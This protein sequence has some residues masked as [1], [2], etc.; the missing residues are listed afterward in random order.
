MYVYCKC[1]FHTVLQLA[2][3]A[4]LMAVPVLRTIAN[5]VPHLRQHTPQIREQYTVHVHK[6]TVAVIDI[7]TYPLEFWWIST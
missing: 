1:G 2:M 5:S 4:L 6:L 7:A 3:V